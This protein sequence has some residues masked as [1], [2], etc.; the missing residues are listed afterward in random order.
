MR[1]CWL[2]DIHFDHLDNES[3]HDFLSMVAGYRP[4]AVLISGDIGTAERDNEYFAQID[5]TFNVPIYFVLGNHDFF[6]GAFATVKMQTI[7]IVAR[8]RNLHWLDRSEVIMLDETTSLIGHSSWADGRFGD[9]EHSE[10][11]LADH[12]LIGDLN[13]DL[14]ERLRNMQAFTQ[15][16]ADHF[17]RILP[18]AL[19]QSQHVIVVTHVPPFEEAS[20]FRGKPTD[21]MWLPFYACKRVGEVLVDHMDRYPDKRMTVLCGHTHG[22]CRYE[23]VPNLEVRVGGATYGRPEIQQPTD[24]PWI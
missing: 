23:P 3:I 24:W 6:H 20:L 10:V 8:S 2:T 4:Q 14:S 11:Q 15:E 5:K 22:Q 12:V 7:E 18:E 21:R 1:L 19:N 17:N 9:Y 13:V 16:A